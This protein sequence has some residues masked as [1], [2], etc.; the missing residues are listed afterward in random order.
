MLLSGSTLANLYVNGAA[1]GGQL[2]LA[3]RFTETRQTSEYT[4]A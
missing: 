3:G 1:D 4:A 2:T